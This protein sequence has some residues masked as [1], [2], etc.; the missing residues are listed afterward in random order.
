MA[1]ASPLSGRHHPGPQHSPTAIA[2][3]TSQISTAN[4]FEHFQLVGQLQKPEAEDKP[5]SAMDEV[6]GRMA[7]LRKA[8]DDACAATGRVCCLVLA[9]LLV[10]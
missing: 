7:E 4:R 5:R 1:S 9:G 6:M 8:L 10:L 2:S 3:G